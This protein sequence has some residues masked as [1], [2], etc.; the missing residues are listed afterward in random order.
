MQTTGDSLLSVSKSIAREAKYM[1]KGKKT[2]Y[3]FKNGFFVSMVGDGSTLE[4]YKK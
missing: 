4:P 3:L 2:N 1:G